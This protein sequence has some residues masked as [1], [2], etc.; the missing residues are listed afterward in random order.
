MA[1]RF[2]HTADLHLESPFKGSYQMPKYIS[3]ELRQ[4]TFQAFTVLIQHAIEQRP[5]FILIVGDVYDGE[6]RSLSAQYNFQQQLERLNKAEIPVIISYGNHDHLSGSWTRLQLPSN[7]YEFSKDVTAHRLI[8][9]GQEVVIHGF[10]YEQRHIEKPMIEDYP[11][12]Q[13]S[14]IHIGMLHGSVD[15]DTEHAVYAPFTIPQLIEKNYDYW[16]LG[17]IHK[18]QLLNQEPPIIYPGNIQGRHRKERDAKGF[19]DV[20][21]QA[22][23]VSYSFV[24]TTQIRYMEYKIDCHEVEH[25]VDLL[26]LVEHACENLRR[27]Y[28]AI[29]L[30]LKLERISQDFAK[31]YLEAGEEEWLQTI[32]EQQAEQQPFIWLH[33]MEAELPQ[34]NFEESELTKQL[35]EKI[36][37]YT[38]QKLAEIT[39]DLL[40][41]PKFAK[42]MERFSD[43]EWQQ[44]QQEA[45]TNLKQ[46]L[47]LEGNN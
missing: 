11:G 27:K 20:Q 42:H 6:N 46:Y 31:V 30:E 10:S 45:T 8:I 13:D 34:Q 19:Y 4:S 36:A 29:M 12:K 16:A 37:D 26:Q 2:F 5:D 38:P 39:A 18:R 25:A 32:R 22:D 23:E 24:E 43:S 1:I 47:L 21:I 28:G 3:D 41:Q 14:A 40:N 9:R 35:F 33:S 17:H 7:V 15:T 44:L